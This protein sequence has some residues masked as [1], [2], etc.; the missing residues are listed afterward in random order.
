MKNK[1]SKVVVGVIS[2]GVIL[3]MLGILPAFGQKAIT[4]TTWDDM[5]ALRSEAHCQAMD[6]VQQEFE[7]THPYI[8]VN[9]LPMP[10]NVEIRRVFVTAMAGGTE[11]D[12]FNEA[13]PVS[14][15]VWFEQGFLYPLDEYLEDWEYRDDVVEALWDSAREGAHI[16][17]VPNYA[18]VMTLFWRK[19]LF[20]EAGLPA[21]APEDWDELVRF[22]QRLTDWEKPQ[23]GFGIL[24]LDWLS[25]YWE[26][27]VWQA[28]GEVTKKLPTG[29]VELSFTDPPG[30]YAAKFYQDLRLRYNCTQKNIL[31]DYGD[32][33]AD[34][35]A[36]RSA[37][38]MSATDNP[39]KFLERGLTLD[40]LGLAMLP[41]GPTGIK[42]TQRGGAYWTINPSSDKAHRDAAWEY[43]KFMVDP[44][45]ITKR[46]VIATELGPPALQVSIYKH[47]RVSDYIDVPEEWAAVAAECLKYSRA[48]YVYKDRIEPYLG[49]PVQAVLLNPDADAYSELV[50]AAKKIVA[51]VANT[52]LA[53]SAK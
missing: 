25:W 6:A 52:V 3:S 43:I 28:G 4:I 31:A 40:Q 19:D 10:E 23:W 47:I 26:N 14:I 8:K 41:A 38:W 48:E 18:Y 29:E 34:F 11:P 9:R 33:E 39:S 27:F 16:Y 37:M 12:A 53:V 46:W 13:Y 22:A 32:L 35:I 7:E 42:A 2:L 51:E 44:N 50:K 21:R 30:V 36:G 20:E 45:T 17:G 24:G 5:R 1:V 49:P 15:P